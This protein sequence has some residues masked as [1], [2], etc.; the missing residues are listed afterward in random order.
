LAA[1][2]TRVVGSENVVGKLRAVMF[3][4]T[5]DSSY[6]AGGYAVTAAVLGL[7]TLLGIDF[8]AGNTAGI[9]ASPYWNSQT[10]K[11]MFQLSGADLT[12]TTNVSTWTYRLIAYSLDN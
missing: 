6:P 9:G 11:V 10:G 1:T 4:L 8:V 5:G 7:R 12:A 2:I 3:D